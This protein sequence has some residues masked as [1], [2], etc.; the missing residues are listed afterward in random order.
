MFT[1][2]GLQTLSA[3]MGQADSIS[4]ANQQM[5]AESKAV[6]L[7]DNYELHNLEP[8]LPHRTRARGK[9]RT[10]DASAFGRYTSQHA[11][12]GAACFVSATE[13]VAVSVLNLGTP[14]KPGHGDN[15]AVF[16]PERTAPYIALQDVL[17]R[18]GAGALTQRELAEFFEN[19]MPYLRFTNSGEELLPHKTTIDAIRRITIDSARSVEAE[20][21]SLSETRSVMEQVA[22]SSKA[23]ELPAFVTFTLNPYE[24]FMGRP[25]QMRLSVRTGAAD[26]PVLTLGLHLIRGEEHRQQMAQELGAIVEREIS[27]IPIYSG[28]Y[29]SST[30]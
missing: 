30:R 3:L 2:E 9:M 25:F 7:P 29:S 12:A 27:S 24:G 23:G 13:M 20:S 28:S 11:E 26:K 5:P 17:K 19:W 15:L 1:P 22:A 16:E 8:Y 21:K 14:D 18:S 10:S 6:A 4:T